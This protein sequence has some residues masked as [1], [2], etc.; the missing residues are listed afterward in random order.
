MLAGARR[1]LLRLL[2]VAVMLLVAVPLPAHGEHADE[3]WTGAT[4]QSR[5][6]DASL[7]ALVA[8]MINEL[9][10]R[11]AACD[12]PRRAGAAAALRPLAATGR[13]ALRANRRLAAAAEHQARMM[14]ASS[15][16]AH[17]SMDGSTVRERSL[18]AGYHWRVIGEN[19]AAGQRSIAEVL[20]QWLASASHCDNLLDERFTEFGVA[21]ASSPDGANPQRIYW[22][23]VM[24]MPK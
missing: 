4:A 8:A 7:H 13:P 14:A 22:A 9:R 3:S 19:L 18:Q 2:S 17:R 21:R 5:S 16:V 11:V 6:D 24:G 10:N 12:D 20:A 1:S 15:R 23:L